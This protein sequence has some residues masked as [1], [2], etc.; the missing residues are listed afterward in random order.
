MKRTAALLLLLLPLAPVAR[1]ETFEELRRE[2]L[3]AAGR[4]RRVLCREDLDD[5]RGLDRR[6]DALSAGGLDDPDYAD[7]LCLQAAVERALQEAVLFDRPASDPGMDLPSGDL[8]RRAA[9]ARSDAPAATLAAYLERLAGRLEAAP[10]R[11]RRVDRDFARETLER[12]RGTRDRLAADAALLDRHF[13]GPERARLAEAIRAFLEAL[14]AFRLRV[15][16]ARNALPERSEAQARERRK[17]EF[18]FVLRYRYLE[19]LDAG[20][21]LERAARFYLDTEAELDALARRIDR[22]RSW[23]EI[24]IEAEADH[25]SREGLIDFAREAMEDALAFVL[26]EDLVTVPETARRLRVAP[27]KPGGPSPFAHYQPGRRPAFVVVP[28]R[29]GA[30][31]AEA[32]THLRA[33]NRPW[34][35]VVALH[36]AVPGHHLQFSIWSGIDRPVRNHVYSSATVEGWALYMEETMGRRG[37]YPPVGR[38]T[39]LRMKLWRASR[40]LLTLGLDHRGLTRAKASAFLQEKILFPEPHADLAATRMDERRHYFVAYMV[41]YLQIEAMKAKVRAAQGSGFD[42]KR[43]HDALLA[44]GPIPVPIME[45]VLLRRAGG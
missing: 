12:I 29:D 10:A 1:A 38:L 36:E 13:R 39:Q 19:A 32:E 43:F 5:L 14:E 2:Y 6:L 25:P 11:W 40:A 34:L 37:Y 30:S 31:E 22:E 9:V 26:E 33:N 28:V 42:E 16:E 17:R 18:D 23:R 35:R 3:E 45:K 24:L 4:Y 8:L 27:G 21:L 44:F 15:D 41:G 7:Y 20:A